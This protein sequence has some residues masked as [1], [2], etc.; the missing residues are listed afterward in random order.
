MPNLLAFCLALSVAS[1]A[2]AQWMT[3][4]AQAVGKGGADTASATGPI[5]YSANPGAIG[6]GGDNTRGVILPVTVQLV[7]ADPSVTSSLSD[8]AKACATRSPQCNQGNITNAVN[9]LAQTPTLRGNVGAGVAG[10]FSLPW[11]PGDHRVVLFVNSLTAATYA[12]K[13]DLTNVSPT[14]GPTF[15]GN[16]ASAT[17]IK[18]LVLVEPGVGYGHMIPGLNGVYVGGTLK[19]VNAHVLYSSL[20]VIQGDP[21]SGMGAMNSDA[22]LQSSS[23]SVDADAGVLVKLNQIFNGAP[24]DPRVAVVARNLTNPS[25]SVPGQNNGKITES[26]QARAGVAVSPFNWWK[27]AA[28]VDLTRNPTLVD[29][30][31]SQQ[32]GAGMEFDVVNHSD[33]NFPL[34]VGV[35]H[36]LAQPS[37]TQFSA[38]LGLNILHFMLEASVMASPN[39]VT[40]AGTSI[41]QEVAGGL[42]LAFLTDDAKPVVAAVKSPAPAPE[43]TLPPPQAA[44]APVPAPLPP[45]DIA[46]AVAVAPADQP[47]PSAAPASSPA[48][49]PPSVPLPATPISTWDVSVSQV[50]PPPQPTN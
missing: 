3:L 29:G 16:N 5:S 28:D 20:P 19:L 8:A 17:I 30:A 12:Q 41:P 32:V 44:A 26:P 43:E 33:L 23:W 2:S 7:L 49:A 22:S 37:S 27:V 1:P 6:V 48:A 21:A 24:M 47:Q 10:E 4:G 38:G 13:A 39:T 40:V 25:F 9:A 36:N 34:R 46:P 15:V 50:Q 31:H 35:S 14:P 45:S 18:G 42:Q 11:V